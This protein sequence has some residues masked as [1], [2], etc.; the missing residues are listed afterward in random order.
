MSENR[1]NYGN[2]LSERSQHSLRHAIVCILIA[3]SGCIASTQAF[4]EDDVTTTLDPVRVTTTLLRWLTPSSRYFNQLRINDSQTS[5]D[6]FQWANGFGTAP[7]SPTDATT[8]GESCRSNPIIMSNG[9]KIEYEQDFEALAVE[10]PLSLTRTYNRNN[11]IGSSIL[12]GYWTTNYDYYLEATPSIVT[13]WRP[14]GRKIDFTSTDQINWYEQK[15]TPVARIVKASD[16]SFTLYSEEGTIERYE[17]LYTQAYRVVSVKNRAGVGWTYTYY[18]G[19]SIYESRR[20]VRITHTS[21]DYIN[22]SYTNING[23][24]ETVTITNADGKQYKYSYSFENSIFSVLLP[25]GTTTSYHYQ[26]YIGTSDHRGELIGKSYNGIRYSTFQWGNYWVHEYDPDGN[27][28]RRDVRLPISSEHAGGV[29]R[30]TF[31]YTIDEYTASVKSVVETNPLG[32]KFVHQFDQGRMVST[33]AQS[34]PNCAAAYRETTYDASGFRNLVT[35]FN[36]NVTDYDYDGAGRLT[37]KTE[38]AGTALARVTTYEWNGQFGQMSRATKAGLVETLYTYTSLGFPETISTKNLASAGVPGQIRTTTYTYTRHPNG[39]LASVNQDGPIAG[40]SD[41]TT[42]TF[43]QRG[44]LVSVANSLGHTRHFGNHNGMGQPGTITGPNGDVTDYFYDP[45]G[46]I[47]IVRQ[48]PSGSAVDTTYTYQSGLLSSVNQAGGR[49]E[50]Y[51]YDAARRLV[52][53]YYQDS[54]GTYARTRY[55][56]NAMSLPT[57]IVVSKTTEA[58]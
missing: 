44:N 28:Y 29:E 32:K 51:L 58:P 35:D 24:N 8:S 39:L 10:M 54:D 41:Q 33:S 1:L 19:S 38:A 25:D 46:R 21:G 16:G 42:S 18:N 6:N 30:S 9:N 52:E 55:T 47:S 37:K 13:A 50:K 4:A 57:S 22:I 49:E 48:Y 43:D 14:D 36:G 45:R 40:A 31:D 12:S 15:T 20:P 17:P 34:S 27:Y 53:K 7:G 26:D 23:P 5:R 56:Y 3:T 11:E 2:E